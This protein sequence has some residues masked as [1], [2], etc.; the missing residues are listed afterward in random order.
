LPEPRRKQGRRHS[1]SDMM[2]IAVTAVI[3]AAD[4][5]ADVHDFGKAKL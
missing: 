5:W 2:V 1:L 3:C 4:S